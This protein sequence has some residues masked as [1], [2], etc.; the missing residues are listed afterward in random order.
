MTN[1]YLRGW[2]KPE[3]T[4]RWHKRLRPIL[5]SMASL[6]WDK[7]AASVR[8]SRGLIVPSAGMRNVLRRCYPEVE[9]AKVHV[10]P[11]GWWERSWEPESEPE[12]TLAAAGLRVELGIHSNA[13]VLLMLSRISPEKGHDV[14]L[15]ALLE[16]ERRDDY[17]SFPIALVICGDAAYM[18]GSRH[19]EKVRALAAR[20]RRT[21]VVFAGHV[22]GD[23]KRSFFA[24]ADLYVF[25]SRHESYGLTLVEALAAGLPAVCVD[26]HGARE[27]MREEFGTLV[28]PRGLRRALAEMLAGERPRQKMGDAARAYARTERFQDRAAQLAALLML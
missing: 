21:Q 18:Q 7:Q 15:N 20:L 8:H 22:T 25:P 27:V 10:L 19:L 26:S 13:R 16:W 2:V 11:W 24:L 23:R 1:I 17:P 28:E 5:P 9:S 14:L 4:V 6:V 3:T 12:N